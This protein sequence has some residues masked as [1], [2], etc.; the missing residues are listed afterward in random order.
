MLRI[1][2]LAIASLFAGAGCGQ[3]SSDSGGPGARETFAVCVGGEPA[4]PPVTDF[5]HTATKLT[6]VVAGSANHAAIDALAKPRERAELE[7]KFAY[8]TLGVDLQDE[9]VHVFLDDCRG[10]DEIGQGNTDSDGRLRLSTPAGLGPGVYE[11]RFWVAGDGTTAT[12]YLYVLP[13]GTRLIVTDIDGTLTASDSELFAQVLDGSHVPVAYPGAVELTQAHAERGSIVVYLTGRP[14]AL[15]K[16]TR[17]WLAQ[18]RFASGFLHVTESNDQALPTE[19][20]VGDFKKAWLTALL[21]AGYQV[22]FAYGNA[23]TDIYAYLGSNLPAEHVYIIGDNAGVSGTQSATDD[24]W[25]ARA[26]AVRA[27]ALVSQPFDY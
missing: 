16:K 24:S 20:G 23:P 11:V 19:T 18:L 7:A 22:D 27:S 3:S 8:G 21:A 10:F 4:L 14:Y 1:L 25:Q 13:A 2:S 15:T 26:T 12:S 5:D 9:A 17:E 6:V